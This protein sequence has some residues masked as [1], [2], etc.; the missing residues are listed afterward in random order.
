MDRCPI[1]SMVEWSGV[2][3][4]H[5]PCFCPLFQLLESVS[6]G[7]V[8]CVPPGRL[9]RQGVR[10]WRWRRYIDRVVHKVVVAVA[11]DN[12]AVTIQQLHSSCIYVTTSSNEQLR[13]RVWCIGG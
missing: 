12:T 10:V 11:H 13:A 5:L 8:I 2:A 9:K 6:S 3:R 1:D 4:S 7:R